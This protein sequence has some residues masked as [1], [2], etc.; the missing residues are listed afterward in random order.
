MTIGTLP[1]T[2]LRSQAAGTGLA[3]ADPDGRGAGCAWPT[4]AGRTSDG[5][6]A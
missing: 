3:G 6:V 2:P 5:Y 4:A 1:F